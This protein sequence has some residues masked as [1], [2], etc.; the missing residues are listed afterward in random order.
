MFLLAITLYNE[1]FILGDTFVMKVCHMSN[2]VFISD[3]RRGVTVAQRERGEGRLLI[4]PT[5]AQHCLPSPE[6]NGHLS[7]VVSTNLNNR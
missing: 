3:V 6:F 7:V 4:V 2:A 1:T 5:P